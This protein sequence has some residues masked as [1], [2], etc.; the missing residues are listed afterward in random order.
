MEDN[1]PGAHGLQ[2]IDT[3]KSVCETRRPSFFFFWRSLDFGRK[4]PTNFGEDLLYLFIYLFFGDHIIR[5]GV[6]EDVLGLEDVLE[7]RF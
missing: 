4:N 5:G 2:G 1:D 3:E 7:D 6:L